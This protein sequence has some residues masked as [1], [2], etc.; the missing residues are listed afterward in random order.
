[1][2]AMI[3][4]LKSAGYEIVD[5]HM[6]A[7]VVKVNGRNFVVKHTNGNVSAVYKAFNNG[8]DWNLLPGGKNI[9]AVSAAI[10]FINERCK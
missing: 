6:H 7:T 2:E 1:M 3:N 4:Q 10:K 9:K 8:G 5:S